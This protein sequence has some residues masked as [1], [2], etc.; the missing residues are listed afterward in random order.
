[1]SSHRT[2]VARTLVAIL[3]ALVLAGC[4]LSQGGSAPDEDASPGSTSSAEGADTG[5]T[6]SVQI[7]SPAEGQQVPANQRVDI[8]VTTGSTTTGFQIN[9]EGRV[10]SSVALPPGQSGP[11]EAILAWQ[12]DH[13]GT[14]TLEVFALNGDRVSDP[15]ALTLLVSGTATSSADSSGEC[16][17]RVMVAQL[18]FRSGPGTG[19]S[20]L[21]Q[22]NTGETVRVIGRNADTTWYKVERAAND[23]QVWTINNSQWL[24]PEGRCGTALLVVE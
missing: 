4:N 9:V 17:A 3:I 14:F 19:T 7:V 18:N 8:T 10:A 16:T 22:F 5:G 23:Q 1:M 6:P 2:A 24:Q 20:R 21:G 12:P 11:T 13:E 15:A